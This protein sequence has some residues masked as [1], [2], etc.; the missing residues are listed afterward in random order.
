MSE[1][2][3][4][5]VDDLRVK[6]CYIC[7]EEEQYD[8]PAQARTKWTHP[9]QCTLIAHESCLLHWIQSSQENQTRVE[10]AFKCPQCGADYEIE[11][12]NPPMLRLLNNLNKVLTSTGKV[13]TVVG[14]GTTVFTFGTCIYLMCTSYGAWAVRE[15]LG[16]EMFD[17]I[18]TEDPANWPWHAWLNL[19]LVP[20]SLILSRTSLWRGTVS[21]IVP[22]FLAWPTTL[23]VRGKRLDPQM[24]LRTQRAT[25]P[26]YS[27]P[28]LMSW[29]P[30]P[31]VATIFLPLIQNVYR[32]L[33]SRFQHWVLNSEPSSEPPVPIFPWR[34]EIRFGQDA[35]DGANDEVR[36]EENRANQ[37]HNREVDGNQDPVAAAERVQSISSASVG[38][39]VG[40][41]LLIPRISNFMGSLLFRL[42]RHS[43]LLRRLLA[44][45]PPL[46]ERLD[47]FSAGEVGSVTDLGRAAKA[48]FRVLV[49][50]T[51]SWAEA[52]PVWWRNSVGLGIFVVVKD[53][54]SLLHLYL[55]KRE[56]QTRRV[57]NKSFN[58][59]DIRELDLIMPPP[60]TLF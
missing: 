5:T 43:D 50:G 53:C 27:F 42:S 60:M 14:M 45:R 46:K 9:C 59:I 16:Q 55:T 13:A 48:A 6:M 24:W 29:P 37:Q 2:W 15:F 49:G 3:V 12:D 33:F 56:I 30:A 41:A 57:K 11:S 26:V 54:V 21:P 47:G 58:G 44:I 40:G 17:L 31:I 34:L 22:L 36:E 35:E 32:N 51:R 25:Q 20:V 7:R 8:V 39:F 4:P 1:P 38:R 23:P 18:L 52:D 19:P 28:S 10:K